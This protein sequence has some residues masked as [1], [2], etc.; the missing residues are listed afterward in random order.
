M[1]II[2][3]N[4]SLALG[5][6]KLHADFTL[7]PKGVSAFFGHSG[8]GKTSC[9]R[10]IAG[11]E[12]RAHGFLSVNG[13]VWQDSEKKLFKP[14]HQREVGF[15]FQEASLFP[16][17][18]VQR[19]LE[20]G[21]RAVTKAERHKKIT[22]IAEL[23]AIKHLLQRGAV[24]LSGGERQRVAIARALLSQPKLLLLDEPLSAL[25]HKRKTEILPYLERMHDELNIPVVYVSH[26]AEEVAQ[27]A[28]HLVLFD[29]GKIVA[30]G[31]LNQTL[32][33]LDL[34]DIF[35]EDAAVVV[36]ATVG[37]H[38]D[39]D[40][41]TRLDFPGGTIFVTRKNKPLG[42]AVRCRILARDVSLARERHLDTSILNA[43]KVEVLELAN[44]S[45]PAHLLVKLNAS[46]IP[47]LSRITKRSRANLQ[48][49][50]GMCLWAQIKAVALLN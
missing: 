43:V 32:T 29:Q 13:E 31:P 38:N 1:S 8:S 5:E 11:L 44:T 27:L 40:Y 46:G 7:P 45:N 28:D 42:A 47:L 41:L 36:E 18:D 30:S 4:F 49:E 26:S 25:D 50:V 15:V 20:F 48:L 39:A 9:L 2:Q 23:L 22:S 24:N 17:L 3:A 37:E 19:N 14:V 16:H 10:V 35:T 6:F 12:N 21:M 34:P 33:R